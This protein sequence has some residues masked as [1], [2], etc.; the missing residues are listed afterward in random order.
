MRDLCRRIEVPTPDVFAEIATQSALCRLDK[1]FGGRSEFVLKPNRGS[2]GRGILVITGR[3][4]KYFLR[5]SGERMTLEE[6]RQ[7]L[8][9]VLSGMYSLGGRPDTV[10]VQ[11]LVRLHSTF[12]PVS[13]KGIP[14]IRIIVYR[15]RPAM[16]MLRLPTAA[17]GGRANLHQ[18]G[19]GAG[20]DLESG[21]TIHAVQRNRSIEYHPDTGHSLI[22]VRVPFWTSVLEMSRRVAE[23]VGLG[24]IGVDV[25][26][27]P[28]GGPMLLEAN[29]RPGLAIQ[30]ANGCGLVPRLREIDE[31]LAQP[32]HGERPIR[33]IQPPSPV[34]SRLSA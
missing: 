6:V 12:R 33:R 14:D 21:V 9:A 4:E 29:A 7:H 31:S 24:Y 22:G 17:S 2:G 27:D 16:A 26:V 30:V 5:H 23:T 25:V 15:N 20:V 34:P 11:Q 10:L 1:Y 19:I 13:F 3:T 8:S 28:I 18:G 32:D